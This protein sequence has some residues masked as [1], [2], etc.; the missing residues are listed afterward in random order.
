[1][2]FGAVA[3][4]AGVVRDLLIPARIAAV[5]VS[6]KHRGAAVENRTGSLGLFE[7]HL[8]PCAVFLPVR[9]KDI[10]DL[11]LR[12]LHDLNPP[13]IPVGQ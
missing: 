12:A 1:M 3:V 13:R 9:T 10:G 4:A 6:A 2:A 5:T 11:K 8:M 7:S